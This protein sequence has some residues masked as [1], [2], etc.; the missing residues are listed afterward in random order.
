ME[1][2]IV[3]GMEI[4][5]VTYEITEELA[6]ELSNVAGERGVK[7][8]K[9]TLQVLAA[10]LMVTLAEA[11]GGRVIGEMPD[12]TVRPISGVNEEI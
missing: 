8:E 11:L 10:G 3:P 7:V 12:G 2:K 9:L 6:E 4:V 5:E 1:R